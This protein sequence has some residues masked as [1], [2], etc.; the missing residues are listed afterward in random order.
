MDVTP[1]C[2]EIKRT[3]LEYVD[4]KPWKGW[5]NADELLFSIFFRDSSFKNIKEIR[6]Y[7]VQ[8]LFGNI[9][10]YIGL[11]LGYALVNM[12]DCLIT[13]FEIFQIQSKQFKEKIEIDA[14]LQTIS[15]EEV[16]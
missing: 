10:G 9:G 7:D 4:T 2:R 16:V 5:A 6:E 11:F 14:S 15:H 13:F 8:D 1:P 3:T 12:P